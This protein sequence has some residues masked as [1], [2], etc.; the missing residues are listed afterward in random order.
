[1]LASSSR[2][3]LMKFADAFFVSVIGV[4]DILP[5]TSR[6]RTISRSSDVVLTGSVISICGA[7][8]YSPH[9]QINAVPLFAV[10]FSKSPSFHV[11]SEY[12]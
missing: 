12:F 11:P 1:M 9:S 7:I 2:I 5:E 8:S 4:P 6:T 10:L 3:V